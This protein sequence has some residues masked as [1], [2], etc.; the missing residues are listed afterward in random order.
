MR[1]KI[2]FDSANISKRLQTCQVV[3][4]ASGWHPNDIINFTDEVRDAFSYEEAMAV[5][6]REFDVVR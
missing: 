6:E 5:I 2:A 4:Q 3:A 1:L